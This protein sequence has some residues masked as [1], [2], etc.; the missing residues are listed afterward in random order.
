MFIVTRNNRRVWSLLNSLYKRKLR[1]SIQENKDYILHKYQHLIDCVRI[2]KQMK[3]FSYSKYFPCVLLHDIG[4]F[5]EYDKT[6]SFDHALYGYHFLKSIN[7]QDPVILLPI[8][9]HENDIDWQIQLKRDKEY[10]ESKE[11]QK[12][13]II[14]GCC[15]VRDI[16]I[17]SNMK[18]IL[19]TSTT[20]ICDLDCNS[21]LIHA[22]ASE[23]IGNKEDIENEYDKITYILCGLSLLTFTESIEYLRKYKIVSG[24]IQKLL[25][26]SGNDK[27]K[28]TTQYISDVISKKYNL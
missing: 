2:L 13:D 8:K 17:I 4:C 22:L 12:K 3:R 16:D 9:Y 7:I 15:L 6:G 1:T 5:C 11:E 10:Q 24:L 28:E 25:F 27:L 18:I 26:L 21:D 20:G 19:N 14:E 23:N